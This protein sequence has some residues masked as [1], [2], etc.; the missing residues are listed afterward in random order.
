MSPDPLLLE[1]LYWLSPP[2]QPE[3]F[4]PPLGTSKGLVHLLLVERSYDKTVE[5][6]SHISFIQ[7]QYCKIN[8]YYMDSHNWFSYQISIINEA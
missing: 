6:H 7:C 3:L 4:S 2:P 5:I 8:W 1:I